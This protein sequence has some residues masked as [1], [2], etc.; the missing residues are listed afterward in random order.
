[1]NDAI[2]QP[3]PGHSILTLLLQLAMLLT[4]ARVLAELMRRVGQ[5]AVIGELL[6]GILLGP[7]VLGHFSP[8][9]FLRLFPADMA[10]YHLLEVISWLGMILLL[11]L[12]GLETDLR[13]VRTVG[14]ATSPGTP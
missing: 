2:L 11:L 4:L 14:R 7:T 3:I 10:Q 5:P 6:A 12:T 13:I 8:E 1:M 9:L